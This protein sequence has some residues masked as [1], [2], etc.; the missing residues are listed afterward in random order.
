MSVL[1]LPLDPTG[2]AYSS[3]YQADRM[4]FR[5][6]IICHGRTF[7]TNSKRRWKRH[8]RAATKR[9][10]P[11]TW[12]INRDGYFVWWKIRLSDDCF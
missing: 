12:L 8:Y 9:N 3:L 1:D 11:G 6:A 5:F 10:L 7:F 4:N 2:C